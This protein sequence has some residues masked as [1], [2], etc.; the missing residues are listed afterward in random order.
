ME[1]KVSESEYLHKEPW[2][3]VR[4]DKCELPNGTVVPGFFVIEYPDWVNAFALTDHGQVIMVKQYRHGFGEV[5][6]ELP[7]GVTEKGETPE[8]AVR[9]EMKEETGYEFETCEYLGKISANPSTTN[10]LTHMFLATG[11]KKTAEQKLDEMEDLELEFMSIA[12][13][14]DL[15]K[16]NKIIQSLHVNCIMYALEK[17]GELKY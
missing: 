10:N 8:E 2:L 7:G 5:G 1:W 9:R 13:V 4:K 15:V 6:I 16:Q 12:E 3:T 11:G 14:K 17:L